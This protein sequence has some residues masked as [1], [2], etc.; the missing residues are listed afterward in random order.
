MKS[1]IL[2]YL[3]VIHK[4]YFKFLNKYPSSEIFIIN[5]SLINV[6]DKE[7]DYLRKEIRSLSPKQANLALKAILPKREIKLLS[8]NKLIKMNKKN[9]KFVLPKEDIFFWLAEKYLSNENIK[10]DRTFLRWNRFNSVEK[11]KIVPSESLSL[12]GFSKRIISIAKTQAELSSDWWRQ[13]GAVLLKDNKIISIAHNTHLP[14]PYTPYID[15]DP[16]NSFHKG[17]NIEI[18]TAIHA[19]AALIANAAKNGITLN[20]S[21]IYVTTFPCPPCAK[22]VACSGISK[23]FYYEGYS[24]TDGEELLK[25][26]GVEIIKITT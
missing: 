13:V 7:F 23:L 9:V 6:I 14:S 12:A 24:M 17:K 19:E 2:I 25:K 8:L 18:S 16:R 11:Q 20:K 26:S 21:E 22:L 10:F 1:K 3:P 15:S 4:G 5:T